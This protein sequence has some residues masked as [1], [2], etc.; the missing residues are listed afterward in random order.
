MSVPL[1]V[2]LPLPAVT[3][4]H[5]MRIIRILRRA[6]TVC[7]IIIIHPGGVHHHHHL[8]LDLSLLDKAADHLL[9]R[10][11]VLRLVGS[12]LRPVGEDLLLLPH[13]F[14]SP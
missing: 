9:R 11:G 7:L 3:L 13:I 2:V 12:R 8:L 6:H 4:V 5:I 1:W 14:F 10:D